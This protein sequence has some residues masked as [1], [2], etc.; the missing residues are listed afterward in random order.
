MVKANGGQRESDGVVV[1]QMG[2]HDNAPGGKGPDFGHAGEGG[3]RQG[4]AGIARLS[5]LNGLPS[6]GKVQQLQRKLWVAAKLS[7]ERRFHALYD[8]VYR[9]D[10]LEEAWK[11][12]RSNRGAAG[13]DKQTLADVEAYGVERL[14]LELQEDLRA[15]SYIPAP[16]RRQEIPKPGGGL[17][18]LSIPTV[19]D[20]IAQAAAKILLEP[21]FEA[22]FMPS[23][24]GYRPGRSATD[25]MEHIRTAFPRGRVFVLECDIRSFFENLDHTRLLR[26][27]EERVSDRRAVKLVRKWLQ[28][29]VMLEGRTVAMVNGTPQ[30][31]VISPLLS[32]IYLHE[33]DREMAEQG[34][35]MVRYADD[36]V[37]LCTSRD[38]AER[39]QVE[40]GTILHELGLKL[41]PAKTRVVDLSDGREGFDFLGCHFHARVSGR[42][43]ERGIRRYYLQRWPSTRSMKRFREKVR[44]LTG[45]NR[46]GI[47]DVR[48]LIRDLN[49]VLIGWGNYFRTGNAATK[50]ISADSYVVRRLRSF[51][52]KRSGRNLHAGVAGH[53]TQE[54]FEQLGLRRLR[55]TIRY[56]G[57]A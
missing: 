51:L 38:E 16:S 45:R 7:P 39:A 26:V 41:N 17:R 18:P 54:W 23:S 49:P 22:D 43:L 5:D 1:P 50:F 37:V 42:M 20:R 52:R 46:T 32:N 35:E 21:I 3:T 10:V 56:P 14:L 24:Y 12:V 28:A 15:G 36:F 27:M 30:G 57:V 48:L 6:V 8:R 4:I 47:K 29:G 2:V 13:V 31:G 25:A 53:W 44:R 55:G 40:V 11:R 34:Y 33:L 19:R 9:S